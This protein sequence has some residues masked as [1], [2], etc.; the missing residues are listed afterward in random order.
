ME[1]I[2]FK[3]S[4][5]KIATDVADISDLSNGLQELLEVAVFLI[6][7]RTLASS[8]SKENIHETLRNGDNSNIAASWLNV[9]R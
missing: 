3:L 1:N 4:V 9:S 2:P 6:D 8:T 7:V 5:R